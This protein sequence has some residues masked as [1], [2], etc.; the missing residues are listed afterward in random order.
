MDA[1]QAAV[2]IMEDSVDFNAGRVRNAQPQLDPWIVPMMRCGRFRGR[3][4][5]FWGGMRWTPR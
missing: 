1:V 2:E 3:R 4:F 5:T